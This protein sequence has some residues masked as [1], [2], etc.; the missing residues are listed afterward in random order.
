[1][2]PGW[3]VLPPKL[4]SNICISIG[5][6]MCNKRALML[7]ANETVHYGRNLGRW[8]IIKRKK[9]IHEVCISKEKLKWRKKKW[10]KC[11][12]CGCRPRKN[13]KSSIQSVIWS[14]SGYAC[15][16][17]HLFYA[18]QYWRMDYS[19]CMHIAHMIL[20]IFEFARNR[21]TSS[22]PNAG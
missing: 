21:C 20:A 18:D 9:Y 14:W 17:V 6:N 13:V 15:M 2:S 10:I 1:M 8:I 3:E 5:A 7:S 4:N 19:L 22:T 16:C 12:K 11:V